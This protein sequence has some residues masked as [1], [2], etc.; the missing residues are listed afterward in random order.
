MSNTIDMSPSD[1][2]LENEVP[3][4]EVDD[5]EYDIKDVDPENHD[6]RKVISEE[7]G[8]TANG[9]PP[10]RS[11]TEEVTPNKYNVRIP[12]DAW[13]PAGDQFECE[14]V[15]PGIHES[16]ICH[17]FPDDDM[18]LNKSTDRA[19]CNKILREIFNGVLKINT[20]DYKIKCAWCDSSAPT[21]TIYIKL[22]ELPFF[23]CPGSKFGL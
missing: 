20:F 17:A 1:D 22:E 7:S 18:M 16:C 4:V 15:V 10:I 3:S 19:E 13:V 8:D 5:S 23:D 6:I 2:V 11:V 12:V 21:E 14:I 9:E